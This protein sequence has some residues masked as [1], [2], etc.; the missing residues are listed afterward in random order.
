[1][2]K[3][4]E[5]TQVYMNHLIDLSTQVLA[6]SK[7]TKKGRVLGIS[8]AIVLYLAYKI[9]GIV[10]PPK[11]LAHIPH[12]NY[13]TFI[14]CL[15]SD[16]ARN[17]TQQ[18]VLPQVTAKESNGIYLVPGVHG[19]TIQVTSPEAVKTVF[20]RTDIFP[21]DRTPV[22]SIHSLTHRFLGGPSILNVNGQEWK[23]QRKVANPAFH[24]SMP[25]QL[26][27]H[28]TATLFSE[29]EK[30]NTQRINISDLVERFTLDAIG[31]AGFD[32]DFNALADRNNYWV[33]T[34]HA[35]MQGIFSPGYA[36]FPFIEKYFL[37]LFPKRKEVHENLNQF[38]HMVDTI[39]D[40]KRKKI[41]EGKNSNDVLE[42]NE[43]DLLTLML[44]NEMKGD[45]SMTNEE[46]KSNICIFFLA[47]HDTT[48]SA[49]SSAIYYMAIHQEIQQ[50]AREEVI[51]IMGNEPIDILP[52]LED[53]KQ[54][55]Y[56]NMIIKEVLRSDAP[57]NAVQV[58]IATEDTE[59]AG[60]FV[61][62]GTRVSVNISGTHLSSKN[63]HNA[64]AFDPERF[65]DPQQSIRSDWVPFG[66]GSRQCIGMNFSLAEQR[67]FFS[68]LLRK[69]TWTL[70][71]D[72]IHK[73]GLKT[74][75]VDLVSP[76]DLEI[77]F[78]RRY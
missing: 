21:K 10:K 63:W 67:V 30:L 37:W 77:L 12:V 5:P 60:S 27:G 18:Y 17:R 24:R 33:T 42:E 50:R 76:K 58:R 69:Y 43:K 8:A 38:L 51:S 72:S 3:S 25:V 75:G 59:L 56:I 31:K 49:I 11:T 52:T 15:F 22:L 61:P 66:N 32:F 78:K 34:Y 54:L 26:F 41:Q 4:M 7:W 62:K 23:N 9:K 28:L 36:I 55:N 48:S 71:E 68:M 44:E 16:S 29:M 40:E 46:L 6:P 14:R 45:D 47:G 53:I 19:W 64:L 65:S 39:I 20:F 73:N 13:F 1:M 70:P 2:P 74:K 57:L 35:V